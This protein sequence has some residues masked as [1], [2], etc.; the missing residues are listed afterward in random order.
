M[1]FTTSDSLA[2]F[3]EDKHHATQQI[4]SKSS[5]RSHL[6]CVLFA[7]QIGIAANPLTG[8]LRGQSYQSKKTLH[9]PTLKSKLKRIIKNLIS[10]DF[11]SHVRQ[12]VQAV[13]L[14]KLI[15]ITKGER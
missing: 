12:K 8:I 2:E 3:T 14:K 13:S 5:D 6:N 10:L 7:K 9:V 15:T 4:I 1:Q 11:W